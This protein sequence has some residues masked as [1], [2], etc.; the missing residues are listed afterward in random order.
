MYGKNQSA[1]EKKSDRRHSTSSKGSGLNGAVMHGAEVLENLA[2]MD[3]EFEKKLEEARRS[4]DQRIAD[5][6][7]KARR[8][9]NETE[10]QIRQMQESSKA[11][12][13]AECEKLAI[14]AQ[15]RAEAE[16][17]LIRQQAEPN[18]EPAVSFVLL[19][20]LP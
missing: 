6:Q 3:R 20:V 14:E 13:T 4:A 1:K 19:E 9:L 2:A 17:E 15:A 5:A 10:I 11:R 16:T 8:I 7:E 18:I 12:I